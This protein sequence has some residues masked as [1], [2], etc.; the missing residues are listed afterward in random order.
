MTKINLLEEISRE[1]WAKVM[2]PRMLSGHIQGR[3]L[4]YK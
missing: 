4:V 1:T 3:F 2:N